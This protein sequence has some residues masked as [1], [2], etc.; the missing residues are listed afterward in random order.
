ML[1]CELGM[2]LVYAVLF[3]VLAPVAGGLLAG[4]DRIISARMQRRVGPGI[5]QPFYDVLKLWDKEGVEGNPA[6]GF[7]IFSFL[8]FVVLSGVFFFAGGDLLLVIFTLTIASVLFV[9]A[10]YSSNSPYSQ[11]SAQR[12]LLQTMAY[13]PMML[14]VAIGFYACCGSFAVGDILNS[15]SLNIVRMPGLFLGMCFIFL[16]KF[17]KSP[18]DVAMS[19][20]IHQELIQGLATEF[21]GRTLALI[22]VAH[23]YE[24]VFLFGFVYLFFGG[25]G[26]F[27]LVGGL[28]ACALVYFL[29][30]L[31]DNCCSRV[32]W[33]HLLRCSWAVTLV[34][35][36]TNVVYLMFR[37]QGY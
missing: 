12:E 18:F 25:A 28:L 29:M 6:Q 36:F 31:V 10:A 32:K 8:L 19:H 14:L 23:W 1:S 21:S 26:L 37:M 3:L 20:E 15:A 16:I 9:T 30:I 4:L 5:L 34:L 35:G 2:K 33:Q 17:R 11:V 27:T 22:E 24:D 7:Y 13:E